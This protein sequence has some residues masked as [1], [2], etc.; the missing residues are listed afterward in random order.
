MATARRADQASDASA[1]EARSST[2]QLDGAVQDQ[3]SHRHV[4]TPEE[5][6]ALLNRLARLEGHVGGVRRMIANGRNCSD[7][8]I[9]LAAVRAGVDKV[10]RLVLEDHIANCLREAASNGTAED[11]WDRLKDAL[12]RYIS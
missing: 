1:S 9:Q 10:A 7:V 2:A 3:D 4:G 12:D 11:E 5:T 8:L 6:R